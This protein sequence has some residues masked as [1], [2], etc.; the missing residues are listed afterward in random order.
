M[1][2]EGK[3]GEEDRVTPG[4]GEKGIMSSVLAMLI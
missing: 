1:A 4:I 3:A 2:G